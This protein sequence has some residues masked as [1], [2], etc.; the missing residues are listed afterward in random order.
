MFP[1]GASRAN[2]VTLPRS[3]QHT[4]LCLID[5]I[6]Q[7]PPYIFLP[8]QM[9]DIPIACYITSRSVHCIH[10]VLPFTIYQANQFPTDFGFSRESEIYKAKQDG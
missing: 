5:L 1:S 2:G 9:P 8:L 4:S 6:L 10:L 7:V 3:I